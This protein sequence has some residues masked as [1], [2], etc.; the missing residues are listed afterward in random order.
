MAHNPCFRSVEF[1]Q[2]SGRIVGVCQDQ[3]FPCLP[4]IWTRC[5]PDCSS[6]QQEAGNRAIILKHLQSPAPTTPTKQGS[7]TL[8]DLEIAQSREAEEWK[9]QMAILISYFRYQ[10][11]PAGLASIGMTWILIDLYS[12]QMLPMPPHSQTNLFYWNHDSDVL[13]KNNWAEGIRARCEMRWNTSFLRCT[14]KNIYSV[15]TSAAYK[16]E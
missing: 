7:L 5:T 10:W 1:T 6:K 2:C 9:S 13:S 16:S 4:S 8:R 3:R 12:A 11:E 15:A 14:L